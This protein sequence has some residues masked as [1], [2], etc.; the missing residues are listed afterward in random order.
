M[1]TRKN[2]RLEALIGP[3]SEFRGDVTTQ[4]TFRIDGVFSGNIVADWVILGE[5]GSIK[6]DITARSVIIGG[7]V[8][9]NVKGEELVEIKHTGQLT[10][11]I[12]TRKLSVAEGGV[13]EG[14]S[15]VQKDET[16]VVDF[17]SKEAMSK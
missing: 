6:G 13:F 5:S 12:S 10:G 4:G 11:D 15:L 16:K 8:D 7:K 1:F 14:R 2:N 9:G 17:P 3:N